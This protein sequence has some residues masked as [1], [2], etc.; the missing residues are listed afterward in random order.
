MTGDQQSQNQPERPRSYDT[1]FACAVLQQLQAL[2]GRKPTVD[3]PSLADLNAFIGQMQAI[4]GP[5]ASLE[6]VI[7]ALVA[8]DIERQLVASRERRQRHIALFQPV[9]IS[10]LLGKPVSEEVSPS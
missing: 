2:F 1:R 7:Q 8:E 3:D 9:A 4:F 5:D 6:S 10:L